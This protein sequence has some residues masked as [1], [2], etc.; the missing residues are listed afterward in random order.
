MP[1]TTDPL[2]THAISDE[3][4]AR[5]LLRAATERSYKLPHN[6]AGFHAHT[7]VQ[8][9]AQIIT[10]TV[11]V[12]SP[13]QITVQVDDASEQP[14]PTAADTWLQSELR[15]M[16]G[17]RWPVPFE[18][19]D[20]RYLLT[21]DAT[22]HALGPRIDLHGDPLHSSYRVRGEQI[23]LVQ[24]TMG[25]QSFTITMLAHTLL[26]DG[27]S[28]PAHYVVVFRDAA[29][30]HIIRTDAYTD[31]FMSVAGCWLPHERQV[32]RHDADGMHAAIFVLYEHTLLLPDAEVD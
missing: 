25:G 22:P 4:Q 15:S 5:E 17:H 18:Q 13:Q 20:G 9:G 3:P 16:I 7:T 30:Q 32:V 2:P 14:A 26:P 10:G 21:Q 1:S 24:R 12:Q 29:S 8:Y 31:R 11:R 27:R 19:R 23:T 28:L 6:F